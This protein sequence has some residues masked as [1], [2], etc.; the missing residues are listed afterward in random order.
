MAHPPKWRYFSLDSRRRAE[1]ERLVWESNRLFE[2]F[3]TAWLLM[4]NYQIL[5]G[6]A[7]G[8]QSWEVGKV[9]EE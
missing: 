5:F 8:W 9:I 6:C 1:I 2:A 4:W 7:Q 3:V